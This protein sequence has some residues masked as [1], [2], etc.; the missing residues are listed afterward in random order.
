MPA[1]AKEMDASAVVTD[2]SPLR[3]PMRWVRVVGD[4]LAE[5]GDGRPLFQVRVVFQEMPEKMVLVTLH[6]NEI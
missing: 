5:A 6:H 3:D 1:F 2:M 4:K